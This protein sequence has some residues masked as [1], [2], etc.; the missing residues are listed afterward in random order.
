MHSLPHQLFGGG[1]SGSG[2]GCGRAAA[3][4]RRKIFGQAR[5]PGSWPV[6]LPSPAAVLVLQGRWLL[7]QALLV[8]LDWLPP[9]QTALPHLYSAPSLL[10]IYILILPRCPVVLPRRPSICPDALL[11]AQMP[12]YIAL[13]F[14]PNALLFCPDA[15]LFCPDAP[16]FCHFLLLAT[17]PPPHPL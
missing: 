16:L 5:P 14:W 2:C 8:A 7:P 13:I 3:S 15:L 9:E 1:G 10:P 17:P 6:S 4:P 12:Y 11:F